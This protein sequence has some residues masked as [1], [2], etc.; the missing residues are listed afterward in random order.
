[1]KIAIVSSLQGYPE[2]TSPETPVDTTRIAR[3]VAER[4]QAALPQVEVGLWDR[5]DYPGQ[6][7]CYIR[8][9]EDVVRWGAD[10]ALHIHQDAYKPG[11]RGWC[12]LWRNQEA[13]PLADYLAAAMRVIPSPFRGIIY[14]DDVAVLKAPRCSVLV[15][16]GF[17]TSPEDEAIGV[18]GWG[19]PLVRGLLNYLRDKYHVMPSKVE[20]VS[21]VPKIIVPQNTEMDGRR[22][23]HVPAFRRDWWLDLGYEGP[24]EEEVVVWVNAQANDQKTGK[25]PPARRIVY[26]VPGTLHADKAPGVH[27]RPCV[28]ADPEWVV[29]SIHSP[30]PLT[31]F[32]GP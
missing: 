21:L 25:K 11:M 32:V 22:V 20:E 2:E 31:V 17:Y 12:V 23:Y 28:M 14:R 6:G 3:H 13:R 30:V 9:R 18:A 16:C 24:G 10:I 8:A 26:K 19:D 7:D 15:E 5:E 29:L 1:M 27:I 4:L